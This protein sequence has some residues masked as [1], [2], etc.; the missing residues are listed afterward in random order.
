MDCEPKSLLVRILGALLATS[1]AVQVCAQEGAP[2]LSPPV[3]PDRE[4]EYQQLA[5]EGALLNRFNQVVKQVVRL[6]TPSV[7]HIDAVRY[8]GSGPFRTRQTVEESGSGVVIEQS[9]RFFVL[10]N[11]HVV[12]GAELADIK[13]HLADGRSLN[14]QRV[15]AD[16]ASDV[17]VIEVNQRDLCA[18]RLGNSDDVEIGDF[19]LAVGSP[20]GLSHSVSFGIISAKGRW[21]PELDSDG[22]HLQDFL[23]TDAAINP[24]NSGGPLLNLK[25]EVIGINTAIASNSGGSEGVGFSIPINLVMIVARRLIEDGAFVHAYLGVTLNNQFSAEDAERLGLAR[26]YGAMVKSIKPDSPANDARLQPQDVIIRFHG[27]EVESDGHLVNLV[28]LAP[29]GKTVDVEVF[30]HGKPIS[31]QVTLRDRSLYEQD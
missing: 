25:G 18:T 27:T 28:G 29:P 13:I 4:H 14:P 2:I 16:R 24:G 30:R 5:D 21:V 26:H 19:V 20:Y 8:E 7:V 9:E 1:A 17:A 3:G 12:Q 15:V 6:V 22:V 10:T 23:Q 11:R 31:V